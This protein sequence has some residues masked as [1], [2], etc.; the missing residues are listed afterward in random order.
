LSGLVRQYWTVRRGSALEHKL[1]DQFH[2][3]V[4]PLFLGSGRRLFD[5]A[6]PGELRL[7]A[8]TPQP[9]GVVT[10]SCAP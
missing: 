5:G 10:L 7:V 3:G 1:I 4:H 6:A 9:S 2:I 8:A